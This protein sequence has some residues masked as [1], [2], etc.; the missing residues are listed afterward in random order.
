MKKELKQQND[1]QDPVPTFLYV[2]ET[3]NSQENYFQI[4]SNSMFN[5]LFFMLFSILY[6]VAKSLHSVSKYI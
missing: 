1:E 4:K 6:G 5:M 2:L 3:S